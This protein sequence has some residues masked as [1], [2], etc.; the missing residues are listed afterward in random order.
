MNDAFPFNILSLTPHQP[1]LKK[2]KPNMKVDLNEE[3]PLKNPVA[4]TCK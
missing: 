3:D 4:C 2:G 1:S